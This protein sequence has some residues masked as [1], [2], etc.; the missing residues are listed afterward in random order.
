MY[1]VIQ[2]EL[3]DHQRELLQRQ[4]GVPGLGR[5]AALFRD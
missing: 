3:P 4:L 1:P 2:R 5:L